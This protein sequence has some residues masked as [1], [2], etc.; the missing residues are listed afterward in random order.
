V[1]PDPLKVPRLKKPRITDIGPDGKRL[2]NN[3]EE[4]AE[5]HDEWL[6]SEID[7]SITER[8]YS[9]IGLFI[10]VEVMGH[11]TTNPDPKHPT[12]AVVLQDAMRYAGIE[13]NGGGTAEGRE[14]NDVTL[15]V[16]HRPRQLGVDFT[17]SITFRVGRW[18]MWLGQ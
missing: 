11:P 1:A 9:D 13:V 14:A 4:Y 10:E 17:Q 12:S 6:E 8:T 15:L 3:D 5:A 18:I 7:R 2:Y 16:G